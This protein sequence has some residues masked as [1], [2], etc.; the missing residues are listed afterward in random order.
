M[1]YFVWSF[2]NYC[3]LFGDSVKCRWVFVFWSVSLCRYVR[4]RIWTCSCHGTYV[5]VWEQSEV[6]VHSLHLVW[7][8]DSSCLLRMLGLLD[9]ELPMVA[10]SAS[11]LTIG[12]LGDRC[13]LQLAAF[14]WVLVFEFGLSCVFSKHSP[15]QAL[16]LYFAV[17]KGLSQYSFLW[18]Q[19]SS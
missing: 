9:R 6:S 16:P 5:E 14:M 8:K 19:S 2:L 12:A 18:S 1:I 17:T 4:M 10:D 13:V 15:H 7:D 11:H 3:N